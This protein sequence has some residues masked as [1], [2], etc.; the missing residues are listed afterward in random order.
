MDAVALND[1]PGRPSRHAHNAVRRFIPVSLPRTR[2]LHHAA[3]D[4]R[5]DPVV[6]EY[7]RQGG[8]DVVA[9]SGVL[10]LLRGEQREVADDL[11]L[12]ARIRR[13]GKE[14]VEERRGVLEAAP[15]PGRDE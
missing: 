11:R 15:F 6:L 14:P 10:P 13:L 8:V 7:L 2:F 1:R 9:Y 3:T 12:L 4:V 5:P